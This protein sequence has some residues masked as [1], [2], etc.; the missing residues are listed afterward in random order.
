MN[1]RGVTGWRLP[2]V[3]PVNG[4]NYNY[5][6]SFNGSIDVG[7]NIGTPGSMYPGSTASE[8]SYLYYVDLGNK[9]IYALDG[10]YLQ[11]GWGLAN[12]GPF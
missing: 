7:Y 4:S 8:M 3:L 2:R 10:S 9:G 11:P 6:I 1:V 5:N 12:K